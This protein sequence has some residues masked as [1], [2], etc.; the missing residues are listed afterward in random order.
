M[1]QTLCNQNVQLDD[2]VGPELKKDW[3]RW[4]QK[5][6][7]VENIHMSKFIKPQMFGKI[8]ETSLRHFS[9]ASEKGYGQCSYIRL[10]NDEGKIHCSLL[11]GKSRVTPKKFLSIP[12]LELTAAV[13]SVKIGKELT[14]GNITEKFWTDS[15]VVLTYIRSITKR[16]TVFVAN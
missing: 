13:L 14:L 15:H 7:G 6:K 3:E 11:V 10:V 8:A 16:F 5:L 12:R 2:V 4:E 1:L 9:D